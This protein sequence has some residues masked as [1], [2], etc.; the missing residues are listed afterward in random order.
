[1]QFSNKLHVIEHIFH[2][3]KN[4]KM[5]LCDVFRKKY[6]IKATFID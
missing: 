2:Y 1:M 5:Q 3:L 4:V 6:A